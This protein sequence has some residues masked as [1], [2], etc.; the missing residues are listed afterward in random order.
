VSKVAFDDLMV[1]EVAQ[2][3]GVKTGI[4]CSQVLCS[5]CARAFEGQTISVNCS[6]S[7]SFV[8]A[9]I[10][11]AAWGEDAN[12]PEW[13]FD[14]V[15]GM[16]GLSTIDTGDTM[17]RANRSSTI[18]SLV[19]KC[20]GLKTCTFEATTSSLG[21]VRGTEDALAVSVIAVCAEGFSVK[22]VVATEVIEMFGEGCANGC[23]T[24]AIG[25]PHLLNLVCGE[26][27][28]I[29]DIIQAAYTPVD[30]V[31]EWMFDEAPSM[32]EEREV[33]DGGHEC[34]PDLA[35]TQLVFRRLCIGRALQVDSINIH[36]ESAY[37]FS[38]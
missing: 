4:N 38:A 35:I 18:R 30:H 20:R 14:S 32:C 2:K 27:Q 15:P 8:I 12:Q 23:Y 11:D 28:I 36:V 24:C 21:N 9:D 7:S 10:M 22:K 31:E 13:L 19:K 1:S 29:T 33:E 37:D 6:M 25:H 16:C 26:D 17:V 34:V 3:K 5:S